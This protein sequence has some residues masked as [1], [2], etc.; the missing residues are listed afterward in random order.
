MKTYDSILSIF[1]LIFCGMYY[2]AI[3]KLPE[4]ARQYPLFIFVLLLAFTVILLITTFIKKEEKINIFQGMQF[5]QF[6]FVL[7]TAIVYVAMINILGFFTSTLIY[8]LI[9]L[10]GLKVIPKYAVITSVGFCIVV[11]LVFVFFLRV[12]VPRGF[13]IW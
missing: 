8:L 11:Y 2:V 3:N 4:E 6:G 13:I 5:K 9:T 10:L 7:I 1:L 12:P